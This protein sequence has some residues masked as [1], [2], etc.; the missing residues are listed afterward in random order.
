M[1]TKVD[2]KVIQGEKYRQIIE[3]IGKDIKE[4]LEIGKL[5]KTPKLPGEGFEDG[6]R[7]AINRICNGIAEIIYKL[8]KEI[9]HDRRTVSS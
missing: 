8:R 6:W 9:P 5:D 4:W 3:M 2:E 1:D 7:L